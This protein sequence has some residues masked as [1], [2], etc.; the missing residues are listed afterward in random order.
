M[1]TGPGYPG[2]NNGYI[3][4]FEGSGRLTVGFSR[5]P[6]SFA[7]AR[8]A[9]IVKCPQSLGYY[10][11]ITPEE[12]ARVVSM[13]DYVW[14]DG[15]DAPNNADGAESFKFVPFT[16]ERRSNG[17]TLGE[18]FV[19]QCT[20]SVLE[21]HGQIHAQKRMTERAIRAA[22]VLT[23]SGN[24]AASNT[25]TA[26]AIGGGKWDVSTTALLYIKKSLN[27]MAIV[28]LKGS[29]GCVMASDLMLVMNP[30][31]AAKVA[32]SQ[33]VHDYIKSSPAAA[34]E[35]VT[36]LGPNV[37]YGLPS[38]LYGYPVHIEDAVRITS[39]KGDTLASTF[40]YPDDV[41]NM[42]SRPGGITGVYGAPSFS[43]LTIF[44][45]EEMTIERFDDRK[46]RRVEGRVVDDIAPE[47]T[48]DV[49]GY[50]LTDVIT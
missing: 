48:A 12:A 42:V 32:E 27:A 24:W 39:K 31:T 40:A 33:E 21:A 17:F 2:G 7:V 36:G 18:K 47:L 37:R 38:T 20:W 3:P 46:Q 6:A 11:K 26:T 5:N 30:N 15:A 43:T 35:L 28:I 50:L 16:T 41:V 19:Q 10:L 14:P 44:A 49:S 29:I 23:T 9:Q 45:Y 4:S 25:G 8:Y 1:A 13:N 22:T 34:A